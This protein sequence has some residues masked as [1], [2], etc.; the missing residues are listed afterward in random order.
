MISVYDCLLAPVM[1]E[2]TSNSVKEAVYVFKINA[3]A[4]KPDVKIA[5]EKIFKVKV[6]KVN[7]F[8]RKGKL[9]TFRGR[10]GERK[11]SKFAVVSLAEGSINFEG[12]F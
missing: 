4:T 9:R 11:S 12:G 7:L 2:K 8:N 6:A 1:T 3:N 10:I 5:V